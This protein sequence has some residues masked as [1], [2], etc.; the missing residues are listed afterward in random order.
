MA[1]HGRRCRRAQSQGNQLRRVGP[2]GDDYDLIDYAGEK[3][4]IALYRL[5]SDNCGT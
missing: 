1:S 3:A 2:M 5:V 4:V